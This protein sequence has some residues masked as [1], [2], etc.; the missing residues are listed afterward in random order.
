MN[1][2]SK[3]DPAETDFRIFTMETDTTDLRDL[4]DRLLPDQGAIEVQRDVAGKEHA[5]HSHDTDET[6][7]ILDGSVQFYW[8]QGER[9]CGRGTVISLPAGMVHGSVALDEGATYLIAFQVGRLSHH[10]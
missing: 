3:I 5:W 4:I 10:D 9:I 1:Q 8:D 2:M 7:V 6:L